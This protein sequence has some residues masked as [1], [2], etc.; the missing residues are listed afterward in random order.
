MRRRVVA[1]CEQLDAGQVGVGSGQ[2]E[3]GAEPGA[4][5]HGLYARHVC[6]GHA[7]VRG[8]RARVAQVELRL[9]EH[10]SD[11]R[12]VRIEGERCG[13]QLYGAFVVA[14]GEG[15]V[16]ER[17]GRGGRLSPGVGVHGAARRLV[18]LPRLP[19]GTGPARYAVGLRE[20]PQ[21]F[22]AAGRQVARP[23][24][25]AE[26]RAPQGLVGSVAGVG[27]HGLRGGRLRLAQRLRGRFGHVG[28]LAPGQRSQEHEHGHNG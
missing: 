16:A 22:G 2:A 8:G 1:L 21:R 19:G 26:G 28:L 12:T 24:R 4:H 3:V 6:Y 18:V 20:E 14:G 27:G 11:L 23:F 17:T 9:A 13:E 10:G 7:Q 5:Q 15:A 25:G